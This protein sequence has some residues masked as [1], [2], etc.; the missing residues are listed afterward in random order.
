MALKLL[1]YMKSGQ[2]CLV[3]SLHW[4]QEGGQVHETCTVR[5]FCTVLTLSV[6]VVC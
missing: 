6:D 1:P 5:A 4:L 3:T 2:S